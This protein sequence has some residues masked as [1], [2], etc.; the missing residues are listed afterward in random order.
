MIEIRKLKHY[1]GERCVLDIEQ[2]MFETGTINVIIGHNGSGKTTFLRILAGLESCRAECVQSSIPL[3]ERVFCS[4]KPYMFHGTVVQN[5]LKGVVFRRQTPDLAAA[6]DL[7]YRLGVESLLSFKAKRLSSGEMQRVAIARALFVKP[8]LLLLDEPTANVDPAGAAAIESEITRQ[9]AAGTTILVATH[10]PDALR[11]SGA[12]I[13]RLEQGK[14][15]TAEIHNIFDADIRFDA[16]HSW[17]WLN[18]RL[19]I[20]CMADREGRCRI[21][22]PSRDIVIS[23]QPLD[24]SMT[25]VLEGPVTAVRTVD[26]VVELTVDVGIPLVSVITPESFERL[27]VNLGTI[28]VASFKATS[29]RVL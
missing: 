28:V 25:N 11:L 12:K 19:R 8:K 18:N 15:T 13:V 14:P 20:R 17:A 22:A 2:L 6:M 16:G 7:A 4:Q 10:S 26:D 23:R 3:G 9:A 1:F 5:I 29:V 21:V 24:S 27:A